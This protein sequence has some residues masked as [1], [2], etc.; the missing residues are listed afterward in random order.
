MKGAVICT[1]GFHDLS[2]PCYHGQEKETGLSVPLLPPPAAF[3]L[4][5]TLRL[6][7]APC[8]ASPAPEGAQKNKNMPHTLHLSEEDFGGPFATVL[9]HNCAVSIP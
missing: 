8:K 5:A 9:P 7:S 3:L 2:E 1:F 4:K 6:H